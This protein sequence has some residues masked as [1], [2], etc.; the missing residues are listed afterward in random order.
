MKDQSP[1]TPQSTFDQNY[2]LVAGNETNIAGDLYDKRV[3]LPANNQ[4]TATSTV[5]VNVGNHIITFLLLGAC[6]LVVTALLLF[7]LLRSGE[8]AQKQPEHQ[9]AIV[10]SASQETQASVPSKQIEET[11]IST[12]LLSLNK[13]PTPG[14][15]DTAPLP[16]GAIATATHIPPATVTPTLPIVANSTET[17]RIFEDNFDSGLAASWSTVGLATTEAGKAVIDQAHQ[18]AGFN[19]VTLLIGENNWENYRISVDLDLVSTPTNEEDQ[20][21]GMNRE[22]IIVF[23]E[24]AERGEFQGLSFKNSIEEMFLP[25][26]YQFQG[27]NVPR[28]EPPFQVSTKS[29]P[30]FHVTV[31][32][33]T[34]E[35]TVYIDNV[36]VGTRALPK[37]STGRAGIIVK[38]YGATTRSPMI[39]NFRVEQLGL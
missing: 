29:A 27:A 8:T 21:Y 34:S 15:S 33:K 39:D 20:F 22:V 26:A 5:T 3:E 38:V 14:S 4:S 2:Q 18:N 10:P 17:K 32:V 6:I 31:E 1:H 36:L 13:V 37:H 23:N 28:L 24:N 9:A 35:I 11:T 30:Q 12:P 16:Q 7:V 19:E 25:A